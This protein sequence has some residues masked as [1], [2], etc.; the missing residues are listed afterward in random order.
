MTQETVVLFG[1][2]P[3]ETPALDRLVANFGWALQAVADFDQ[4]RTLSAGRSLVA[5][6]FYLDSVGLPCDEALRLIRKIDSEALPILCHKFSD[7]VNWPELVEAGAFHALSV[8]FERSEVRQSLGFVWSERLRRAANL[9]LGN[10]HGY[11]LSNVRRDV[12]AVA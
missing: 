10:G 11:Y 5:V 4:L 12:G 7:V 6:F 9:R 2:L 8:P 1:K 3:V